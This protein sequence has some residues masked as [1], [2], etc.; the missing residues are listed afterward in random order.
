[1]TLGHGNFSRSLEGCRTPDPPGLVRGAYAKDDQQYKVPVDVPCGTEDGEPD[2]IHTPPWRLAEGAPSAT[3]LYQRLVRLQDESS[4]LQFDHDALYLTRD[5]GVLLTST[6]QN[7]QA[8]VCRA[9]PG[10]TREQVGA[11]SEAASVVFPQVLES[12]VKHSVPPP[13]PHARASTWGVSQVVSKGTVGHPTLCASA[14]R[15][16]KRKGGCMDG[17]AC[18]H[19]HQCFWHKGPSEAAAPEEAS[20]STSPPVDVEDKDKASTAGTQ[21]PI[22]TSTLKGTAAVLP[23][24]A[25]T[26]G[27]PS[28]CGEACKYVRRQGG[29]RRGNDCPQCHHCKWQKATDSRKAGVSVTESTLPASTSSAVPGGLVVRLGQFVSP[30]LGDQPFPH[31]WT[32]GNKSDPSRPFSIP[33]LQVMS[34]SL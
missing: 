10:L 4:S 25:G 19:C 9:P 7:V 16:V 13:E 1:M 29:C 23:F 18:Q 28:H 34:F 32:L 14:C 27:H 26:L 31:V 22:S 6:S 3:E 21:K 15:Y 11:D 17:A 2:G 20:F 5:Q 12:S 33:G 24:S 8:N 30:A